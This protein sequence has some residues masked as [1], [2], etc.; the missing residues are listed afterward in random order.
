M[1]GFES[2]IPVRDE[3]TVKYHS[4]YFEIL[5]HVCETRLGTVAGGQF[6]WGGC[7][8]KDNGG[9][10]RSPQAVWQSA[11][12]YNGI[13]GPDCETDKSSRDESRA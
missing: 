4:C 3:P 11:G 1:G 10:Q 9:V 12:E 2:R 5:T 6:D 13:R 8:L 7:L